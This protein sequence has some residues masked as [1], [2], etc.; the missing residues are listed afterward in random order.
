MQCEVQLGYFK[1]VYSFINQRLLALAQ[2]Q[3][4]TSLCRNQFQQ[5][6]ASYHALLFELLLV[7][8]DHSCTRTGFKVHACTVSSPHVRKKNSFINKLLIHVIQMFN[9]K[10]FCGLMPSTNIKFT[11]ELWYL[12]VNCRIYI[13]IYK[14]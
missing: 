5:Q 11:S 14:E 8:M 4:E 1:H 6:L 2:R 13:Y 7:D 12:Y 9:E 10:N 3:P